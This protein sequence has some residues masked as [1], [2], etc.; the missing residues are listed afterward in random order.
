MES[1]LL[2]NYHAQKESF[3][4]HEKNW[5]SFSVQFLYLL[6]KEGVRSNFAWHCGNFNV[7]KNVLHHRYFTKCD[8]FSEQNCIENVRKQESLCQRKCHVPRRKEILCMSRPV[9]FTTTTVSGYRETK[10]S[11]FIGTACWNSD[12]VFI[13][14][15]KLLLV[16]FP[17]LYDLSQASM[18]KVNW[19]VACIMLCQTIS[20]AHSLY[21]NNWQWSIEIQSTGVQI[22]SHKSKIWNISVKIAYNCDLSVHL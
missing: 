20:L 21:F 13:L 2:H 8:A 18:T 14:G 19:L 22:A 12:N 10:T 15:I 1:I 6:K 9:P 7:S 17:S 16:T 3:K 11:E 5:T 4:K